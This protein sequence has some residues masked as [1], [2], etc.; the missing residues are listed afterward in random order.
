MY[1]HEVIKHVNLQDNNILQEIK[2]WPRA[3]TIDCVWALSQCSAATMYVWQ[4]QL[5]KWVGRARVTKTD[6][7]ACIQ[8]QP[9][10]HQCSH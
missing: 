3:L 8:K 1:V 5:V 4:D 10:H 2:F 6:T 9:T 7:Y